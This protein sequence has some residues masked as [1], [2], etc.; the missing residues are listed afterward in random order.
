MTGSAAKRRTASV[1]PRLA[2]ASR[3]RRARA[4]FY[5]GGPAAPTLPGTPRNAGTAGILA[6]H[7]S[8]LLEHF[9]DLALCGERLA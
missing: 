9:D 3:P 1:L 7:R 8:G 2:W 6:A 4:T 5:A